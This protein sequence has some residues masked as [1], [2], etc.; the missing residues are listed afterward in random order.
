MNGE[1]KNPTPY[2]VRCHSKGC[3]GQL[4]YLTSEEHL[5]QL[6]HRDCRWA[7]P[8]CGN[9]ATWDDENYDKHN[10]PDADIPEPEDEEFKAV[11][12]EIFGKPEDKG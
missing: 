10:D 12:D 2:A 4:I 11:L 5:I 7:C 1:S 8:R 3:D 6:G 9:E